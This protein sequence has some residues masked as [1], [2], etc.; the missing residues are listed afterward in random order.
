[1]RG[2]WVVQELRCNSR[3]GAIPS[4]GGNEDGRLWI[5]AIAI[6][7]GIEKTFGEYWNLR[8]FGAGFNRCLC[9]SVLSIAIPIAIP[10]PMMMKA[11][12]KYLWVALKIHPSYGV[13]RGFGKN[14]GGYNLM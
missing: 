9:L 11:I 14:S 4:G 1:L 6:G 13:L 12:V 3:T 10:I 2:R 5:I 8:E 7:I